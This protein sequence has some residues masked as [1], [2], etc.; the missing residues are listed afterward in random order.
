VRI[1]L[2]DS[3]L[4]ENLKSGTKIRQNRFLVINMDLKKNT[5]ET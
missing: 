4:G 3:E 1:I 5:S 2:E